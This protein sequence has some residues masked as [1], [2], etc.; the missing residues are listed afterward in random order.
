MADRKDIYSITPG[1]M[2]MKLKKGFGLFL[3]LAILAST[4]AVFP[5]AVHKAVSPMVKKGQA[6]ELADISGSTGLNYSLFTCQLAGVADPCYDLYQIRHAYGIDSLI[7]AGFDGKGK[8][9]VIVD[10][11]QSPNIVSELNTFDTFY[12]LPGLNGLGGKKN[13]KLGTFTQVAPDGLTPFDET[14]PF[15]TGWAEEITLDVLLAHAMAPGANITLVLSKS[16]DDADILSATQYAVDHNLGDIISQSFGENESCVDT[17]LLKAE[18]ILFVK[19]T[20]KGISL[21][22]A[23]GDQGAAQPTCDG[24]SY[25]LAASSPASDPLVIGVG[26]TDLSAAGYCLLSQGC[27]PKKNPAP[28][29]YQGEVVWNEFDS[30]WVSGGGFSVLYNQPFYQLAAFHSSKM[31]GVPDVAFNASITHG[32]LTWLDVPGDYTGWVTFG[33]TSV[34]TPGWAAILAIAGQ[35]A[36]HNLGFAN[37]AL[38]LIGLNKKT[39]AADFHDITSGNNSVVEDVS[40]TGYNAGS[41]WDATTGFGSP[42]ASQLVNDLVKTVSV[43]DAL[44]ASKTAGPSGNNHTG[45]GK[46]FTH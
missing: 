38:Y 28:G 39:Y 1:G 46:V 3:T 45:H 22:A 27:N 42:A 24:S 13:S 21:V 6:A 14:N 10:A 29:T 20:L 9:I 11:F 31:R 8:T 5:A 30:S 23:S 44:T 4:L 43:G 12:G 41:G 33:G 2:H 37:L 34:G 19:A 35:K 32:I 40:V 7:K 17:N 36:G 26:G 18:H 16:D 25:V 15:H